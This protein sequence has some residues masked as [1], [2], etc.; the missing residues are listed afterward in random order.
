MNGSKI[1]DDQRFWLN[2]LKKIDNVDARVAH[3]FEEA[4]KIVMEMEKI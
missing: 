1:S 3:W 4:K 2:N